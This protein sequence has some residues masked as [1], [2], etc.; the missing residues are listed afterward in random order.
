MLSLVS[1]DSVHLR[2]DASM[3]RTLGVAC[4]QVVLAEASEVFVNPG[5]DLGSIT[6]L[7]AL[8]QHADDRSQSQ[9]AWQIGRHSQ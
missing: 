7:H 1:L 6:E 3:D 2:T 4:G 8:L 9:Q 5:T